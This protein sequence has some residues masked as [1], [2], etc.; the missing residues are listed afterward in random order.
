MIEWLFAAGIIAG[1]VDSIVGG[2]GII[3]LPA[4]LATGMPAHLAVGTN[5]VVG[6]GASSMATWNYA[7]AGLTDRRIWMLAPLAAGASVLGA[8]LVLRLDGRFI[9]WGV[10]AM[11]AAITLY[12][13]FDPRF[14]VQDRTRWRP[15]AVVGVAALALG[16]GFYDGLLGPGTGSLLLFG[17]VAIVGMPRLAASA[18]GRVLNFA[19]NV[20]ALVLFVAAD[21]V[22]WRTGLVMAAGTVLGA[23]LGSRSNIR[24]Q[25]RWVRPLFV[26]MAGAL[27]VRLLL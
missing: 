21:S 16:V 22:V 2:G 3:T 19:S 26:V 1:S 27:F 14:G 6:T 12:V 25:A 18:N 4:L 20:G 15:A 5:K 10:M 23:W 11:M 13:L 17:L 24:S 7:R 8:L 9:L